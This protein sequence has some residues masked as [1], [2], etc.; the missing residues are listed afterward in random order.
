MTMERHRR[1]QAETSEGEDARRAYRPY[2][3]DNDNDAHHGDEQH[4]DPTRRRLSDPTPSRP[5][6]RRGRRSEVDSSGHEPGDDVEV[7]P[8]RFDSYGRPLDGRTT[9]QDGWTTRSGTF[10][11]EPQRPGGWDVSGA[12]QVSG[13]D[14]Q[15][16][17]RLAKNVTGALE[18]QKSWMG[19]IGQVLGSGLLQGAEEPGSGSHV[20]GHGGQRHDDGYGDEDDESRRRRRR[21]EGRR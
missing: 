11:R 3:K 4:N 2:L 18:G 19:V 16:V 9:S 15:A 17:D 7:L 10:R 5:L 21:H 6:V 8:D 20:R 12:W 1:E 14:G 13:T